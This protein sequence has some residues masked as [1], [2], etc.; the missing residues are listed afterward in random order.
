MTR[1]E[2][3]LSNDDMS[4]CHALIS[5]PTNPETPSMNLGQAVAVCLY[6][7]VRGS[8]SQ[9]SRQPPV[10]SAEAVSGEEAERLTQMLD[11]FYA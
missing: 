4:F 9:T 2:F 6:E 3:G 5:I 7:L 10:S 1:R 8:E 11:S